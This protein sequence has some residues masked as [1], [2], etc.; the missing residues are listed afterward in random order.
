LNYV[1][2]KYNSDIIVLEK[3]KKGI[4]IPR[5]EIPL[6]NFTNKSLD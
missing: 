5:I 1:N 6:D 4:G 3:G 2:V